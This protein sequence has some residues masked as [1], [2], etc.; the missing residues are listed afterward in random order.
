[1]AEQGTPPTGI[2]RDIAELRERV[3]A[4]PDSGGELDEAR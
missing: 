1:M 3:G 4:H 2:Y